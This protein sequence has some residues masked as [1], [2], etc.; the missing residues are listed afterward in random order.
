MSHVGARRDS[1]GTCKRC[2][3][4]CY[5]SRAEA[6]KARKAVHPGEKMNVY[7]CGAYWHYGHSEVWRDVTPDDLIWRPLPPV[8]ITQIHAMARTAIGAAA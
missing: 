6:K 5:P 4:Q 7:P 1:V 2:G 8:A 3:K